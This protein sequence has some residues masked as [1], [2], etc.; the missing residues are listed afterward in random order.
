MWLAGSL[1]YIDFDH[2]VLLTEA[3][4]VSLFT[5]GG[6]SY[7]DCLE[8][9]FDRYSYLITKVPETIRREMESAN[10]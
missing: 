9:P 7:Q 6:F 5:H 4:M 10:G 8:M 2:E 1:R 3:A